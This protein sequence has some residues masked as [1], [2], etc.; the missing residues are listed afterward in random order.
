[1]TNSIQIDRDQCV[2]CGQCLLSCPNQLFTRKNHN[3][4]PVI[5]PYATEVCIQCGHCVA[6]CPAG[7]IT[8]DQWGHEACQ[9]ISRENTPRFEY[10]A[11]LVRT[12]RSVRHFENKLLKMATLESLLDIVRWAPSARNAQPIQWIVV[13]SHE[14]MVQLGNLVVKT[15]RKQEHFKRQVEA[16]DAGNDMILRGAPAM[17]IA[18]TAS[19]AIF[20]EVD[21]AIAVEILDLCAAAMQLGSCWAG[22]FIRAAQ[23]DPAI[24]S[25][26]GLKNNEKVHAALLLGY[27]NLEAYKRIPFR[28]ELEIKWIF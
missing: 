18:T 15:L 13:H 9:T 17:V 14:K 6:G 16:W 24:Q 4:N 28:N 12:R 26:L 5:A 20:P 22:F 23:A 2:R 25:W 8:V 11:K 7:A 10:I 19:D 21:C 1:M 27:P 3:E